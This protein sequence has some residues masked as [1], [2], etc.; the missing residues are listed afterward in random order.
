[1]N[2]RSREKAVSVSQPTLGLTEHQVDDR[3]HIVTVINYEPYDQQALLTLAEGW[4][5]VDCRSMENA[6]QLHGSTLHLPHNNG[7]VLTVAYAEPQP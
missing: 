6:A 7:A 4:T 1:M 5:V 2:L 3:Q